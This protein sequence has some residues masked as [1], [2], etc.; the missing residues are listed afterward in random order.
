M[1]DTSQAYECDNTIYF[2]TKNPSA[3]TT[4]QTGTNSQKNENRENTYD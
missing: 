4:Q 1:D 3:R 2:Q